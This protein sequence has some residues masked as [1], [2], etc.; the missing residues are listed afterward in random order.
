MGQGQ[1]TIAEILAAI[2][3]TERVSAFLG[4]YAERDIAIERLVDDITVARLTL[5]G[6]LRTRLRPHTRQALGA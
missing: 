4:R 1:R 5:I 3:T 2:S 6:E